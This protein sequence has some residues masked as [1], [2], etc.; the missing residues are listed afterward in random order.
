MN[1]TV[2]GAQFNKTDMPFASDDD[3]PKYFTKPMSPNMEKP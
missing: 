3:T 2:N 1:T